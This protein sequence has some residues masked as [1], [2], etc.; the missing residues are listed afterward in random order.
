ML[1]RSKTK[2]RRTLFRQKQ[3]EAVKQKQRDKVCDFRTTLKVNSRNQPVNSKKL[4]KEKN[5]YH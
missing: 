5:K 1:T 3:K 4:D 2:Q